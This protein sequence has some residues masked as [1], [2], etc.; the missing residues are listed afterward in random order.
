MK[1]RFLLL[2]IIVLSFESCFEEDMNRGI[3]IMKLGVELKAPT[4][5]KYKND[6]I[7]PSVIKLPV[8]IGVYDWAMGASPYPLMENGKPNSSLE[9]PILYLGKS[10]A[11]GL[12]PLEW[13]FI[14]VVEETPSVGYNSD[15]CVFHDGTKLWVFWREND[16]QACRDNGMSRATFGVSTTDGVNFTEK[17]FFA[18]ALTGTTDA[19]MCPVVTDINGKIQMYGCHYEFQPIRQPRGLAV[20]DIEGNDLDNKQFNLTKTVGQLYYRGF[21]FWHFDVFKHNEKF[22]CVVT[23]ESGNEILLGV[24]NDGES[25]QFWSTPLLSTAVSGAV[26]MYKP[27]ARVI[28][29]IFYLWHPVRINGINKIHMSE[30]NFDLLLAELEDTVSKVG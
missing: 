3:N 7:H 6:L 19:E 21:N 16:T 20:W 15:P 22:Y 18:G 26:Y 14:R 25:F 30:M 9:N 5:E 27:C 11:G 8:N 1:N 17:K 12:P 23:P 10:R 28:D 4:P 24:S 2:I 29:G 13:D